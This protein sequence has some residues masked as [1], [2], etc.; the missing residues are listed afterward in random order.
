MELAEEGAFV[1]KS[2]EG[3]KIL[4]VNEE[5]DSFSEVTEEDYDAEEEELE[6]EL[7]EI[8]SGLLVAE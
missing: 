5:E 4:Q 7:D 3:G 1:R 6:A 2:I 8:K